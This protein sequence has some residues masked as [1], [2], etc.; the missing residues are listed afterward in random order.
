MA[1][2]RGPRVCAAT[3]DRL[4]WYAVTCGRSPLTVT[5]A[6]DLFAT[7]AR[8][9]AVAF[10][11]ATATRAMTHACPVAEAR[12][13]RD[14]TAPWTTVTCAASTEG[15]R[16]PVVTR[17]S[18]TGATAAI[19][20]ARAAMT[21]TAPTASTTGRPI[22]EA[23]GFFALTA[24]VE[25]AGCSAMAE[26]RADVRAPAYATLT[27]AA[28]AHAD[29]RGVR[30]ARMPSNTWT[31]RPTAK[32]GTVATRALPNDP[33]AAL[34][35]NPK[36]LGLAVCAL[37]T[38]STGTPA[39]IEA[40]GRRTWMA[41]IASA[42]WVERAAAAGSGDLTAASATPGVRIS[43]PTAAA[44]GR[45]VS[46]ADT[47]RAGCAARAKV[48]VFVRTATTPVVTAVP[49]PAAR[50]EVARMA[51]TLTA[52]C[53]ARPEAEAWGTDTIARADTPDA[54]RIAIVAAF[55]LT[56]AKLCAAWLLRPDAEGRMAAT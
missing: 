38:L 6:R 52:A 23:R 53:V 15:L 48:R 28:R 10:G 13:R 5:A 24:A 47:D 41:T 51:D 43:K 27:P 2:A 12:G 26:P 7:V 42:A 34:C 17:P 35:P 1:A 16:R 3:A 18:N 46:A 29:A 54:P 20:D 25:S 31:P 36:A 19:A 8:A 32:G 39:T 11:V 4:A 30:A 9:R 45:L 50:G 40:A 37:T 49:R 56:A 44:T 33:D 21:E 22:A 55:T 14:E